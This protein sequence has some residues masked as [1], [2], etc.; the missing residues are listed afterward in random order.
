MIFFLLLVFLMV[1]MV[2]MI[3]MIMMMTVAGR[4]AQFE[5][6]DCW[7]GVDHSLSLLCDFGLHYPL[8]SWRG[9]LP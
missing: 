7:C 9:L 1:V 5:A 8:G 3:M 2:V 6:Q 4:T